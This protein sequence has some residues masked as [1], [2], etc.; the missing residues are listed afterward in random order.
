MKKIILASVMALA[1]APA[2]SAADIAIYYSP[3]CPHCHHARDFISSTLIYE[4]PTLAVVEYNVSENA[5]YNEFA[6]ALKTCG[7][8]SGGVPVAVVNG[9]CFQGFGAP[10]NTGVEFR[11]ALDAK[12]TAAEKEASKNASAEFKKDGAQFR[13]AHPDRVRAISEFSAETVQKKT[14]NSAIYFYGLL[15]ILVAGL[16]FVLF[17]K[18][19][20]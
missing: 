4:Y 3:T 5:G 15:I 20:K 17:S 12:L 18:K 1:A 8:E 13:A 10:E 9:K 6:K 19:K 7:Y 14:S 2:F 11:A 16:G